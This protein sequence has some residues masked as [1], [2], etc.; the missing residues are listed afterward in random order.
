[1]YGKISSLKTCAHELRRTLKLALMSSL[2]V[3]AGKSQ[4]RIRVW[5]KPNFPPFL[6]SLYH[7]NSTHRGKLYRSNFLYGARGGARPFCP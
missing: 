5:S 3:L 2:S 6:S 4:L 7:Y 1:M